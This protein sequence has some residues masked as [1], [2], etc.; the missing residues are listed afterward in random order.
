MQ[1]VV[2]TLFEGDYHF[3]VAALANSL[4]KQ[5]FEGDIYAGYRGKIP[6]WTKSLQKETAIDWKG[7]STFAISDKVNLHFLPLDTD[8]HFT[9]YKP[10][11]MLNVWNTVAKQSKQLFYFD[12]DIIVHSPWDIFNDWVACGVAV[13]E[14]VNSPLAEYHPR[15]VAWRHYFSSKGIKLSFKN[16]I[17]VNGGF[18]GTGNK[19]FL[20]LWKEIQE[21]M[22][23]QIGGL[24]R[25][26]LVGTP[27]L[28]HDQS[29]FS[30]FG[31]TD[32]DA[33]NA[34]IE[35][36]SYEVSFVGQEGMAFKA[37]SVLMSHALG[38]PKP[39]DLMPL[40]QSLHGMPPRLVDRAY[41]NLANG[42]IISQS[43]RTV[44]IKKWS[45]NLSAF[46]GR[47]YRRGSL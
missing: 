16:S 36:W 21:L 34:T 13:C 47:F 41:W 8:Y 31:K 42:I 5:G 43:A 30:P 25:S 15:R 7:S 26:S 37:G 22:A 35:A 17:Y 44:A 32:Q 23:L 1:A 45:I 3:G 12:P 19:K 28:Q 10:D 18:V 33:L 27:L 14:D 46:I 9:N 24:H 29:A 11:F 20:E 4:H 40:R 6:A 39:W 2:C 38:K